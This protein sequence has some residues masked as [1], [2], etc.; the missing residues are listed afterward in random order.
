MANAACGGGRGS[1]AEA[2][3]RH[4]SAWGSEDHMSGE[5]VFTLTI[6]TGVQILRDGLIALILSVE[7]LGSPGMTMTPMTIGSDG[8]TGPSTS[9]S[10]DRCVRIAR[11]VRADR[12]FRG[13]TSSNRAMRRSAGSSAQ[14]PVRP[15]CASSRGTGRSTSCSASRSQLPVASSPRMFVGRPPMSTSAV[16]D[17]MPTVPSRSSTRSSSMS[18]RV[19]AYVTEAVSRGVEGRR[20]GR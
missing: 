10:Q 12:R 8:P 14:C 1:P 19:P 2:T 17:V 15:G 13:T 18:G 4:A 7:A 16:A 5:P 9:A 3:A 6:T 11:P 20:A